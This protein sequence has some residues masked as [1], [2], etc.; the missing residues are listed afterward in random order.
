MRIIRSIDEYVA[1]A[2]LLLTIGVFDGVH[3]GHRSVL[4]DLIR[5]RGPGAR[6]GA[7]TFERH[8]Q[9]FLQPESAPKSITTTDEKV[10]LLDACGLDVL[11]LLPFDERIADLTPEAFLRDVLLSALGTKTLVVGDN[12]RFGKG[13]AGDCALAKRVLESAGCRFEAAPLVG[14]DGDKISSSRIRSLLADRAFAEADD[15]LG[16]PYIV[17]G[18]VTTGDGRGHTLGFP[19]A[20]L[21]VHPEKLVPT[22]GVYGARALHDGTEHIAVV[23]I[24]TKPTFGGTSSTIEAYLVDFHRSIYGEQIALRQWSFVREQQRFEHASALVEAIDRDVAAVRG[25]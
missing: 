3:L 25:R 24:G 2:D 15:L 20:N 7:L 8:P 1:D 23:S 6:A 13:R 10:N 22:D 17:R 19:T 18:T 14:G 12:W 5:R 9:A 4:A 11:F 16:S 21:S